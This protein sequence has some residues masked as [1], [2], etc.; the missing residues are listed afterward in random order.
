MQYEPLYK[1]FYKNNDAY[2]KIYLER[3]H[4]E[5]SYRYDFVVSKKQAFACMNLEIL[6]IV[7]AILELDKRLLKAT[8]R[9]PKIALIQFTK[10]CIIDEI[11]LTNEIEGVYSTRKEIRELMD[12]LASDKERN[13]LYSVVQK[14]MMLSDGDKI[15]LS[16]CQ[17]IRKLYDEFILAEIQAEDHKNLLDGE[18]FRKDIVEVVSASQKT[19]HQGVYPEA[20]I[21]EMMTA[22]LAILHDDQSNYFVNIA[23]FHYM[24]GYIHPFYD[25]NGRMAR[26]ISSYLLMQRLDPLV[27]FGLSYTIKNKLNKY[28]EMFKDTNDLKN[29]GDLTPFIIGFLELVKDAV[30]NLCNTIENRAEKLSFYVK[31]IKLYEQKD[32][33]RRN[34]LYVLARS[35]LFDIE[36]IELVRLAR[37]TQLSQSTVRDRLKMIPSSMLVVTRSGKMHRYS[38]NLD[39]LI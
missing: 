20:K 24:F 37:V 1:I 12:G 22:A 34:I 17:D 6:N 11:H 33:A 8:R 38:L 10:K 16:S 32:K 27:G 36:G 19:I 3:F 5:A 18:L 25:G 23:V 31:K 28:Y 13:R 29:N 39:A 4:S 9:V 30:E 21:I 7:T 15:A 14:Y 26:F 2:E 35:A